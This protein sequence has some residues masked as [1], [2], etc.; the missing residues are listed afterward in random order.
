MRFTA[1]ILFFI[2]IPIHFYITFTPSKNH[3]TLL[4]NIINFKPLNLS[5]I[6]I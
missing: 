3:P 5:L 2:F 6:H 1:Q 4:K